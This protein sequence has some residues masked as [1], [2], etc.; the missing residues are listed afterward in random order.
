MAQ[1][2]AT[3]PTRI[4][5]RKRIGLEGH[6]RALLQ[7]AREPRLRTLFWECTLRCNLHC[8]HCGS[9]CRV[10]SSVQEMSKERFLHVID[11]LTPHVDPHQVLI[12]FTG[13]E[14]LVRPDLEE[15]GLE[16]YKRGYPWGIVTN[17]MLLTEERLSRLL[18]S[19]LHTLTISLDGFAKAHNYLRGHPLSYERA[20]QAAR[21]MVPHSN[22]VAWDIVTC[23]NPMNFP[24]LEQFRA[25]LEEIGVPAWRLFT[26]F[27]VGRAAQD[28]NLQ[29]SDDDF[30]RLMEFIKATNERNGIRASYGCEGFLGAYEGE[31]RAHYYTCQAGLSVASVLADGTISA[32]PSIRFDYKQGNVHQ[33]DLWTVWQK[34]FKPYRDRSWAKRD[35]CAKCEVWRYCQGNGMHL[36]DDSGKLLFCHYQRLKRGAQALKEKP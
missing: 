17:G 26:I 3:D 15:V 30:V 19:G 18:R 35:A 10:D 12:I 29:L 9:D 8:K 13:G 16:L 22:E 32:C 7:Q 23:V 14:A 25:H 28:P 6:R 34:G 27:P 1:S 2:S 5:F 21:L 31:V 20:E 4:P 24:T 36:H 11:T 33:D